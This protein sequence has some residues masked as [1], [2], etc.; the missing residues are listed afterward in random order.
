MKIRKMAALLLTSTLCFGLAQ[1]ASATDCSGYID[2]VRTEL[3]DGICWDYLDG[4]KNG[5]RACDSLNSKLDGAD[6]KI[7]EEKIEDAIKKLENFQTS[8]DKLAF[9]AK[10]II[11]GDE[12]NWLNAP[13]QEARTCVAGLQSL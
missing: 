3:N 6:T 2:T 11:S 7:L 5:K 9:R 10:P 8:L 12:Y 1:V 13:L 4:H